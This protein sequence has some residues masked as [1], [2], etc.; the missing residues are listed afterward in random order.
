MKIKK[1]NNN[2]GGVNKIKKLKSNSSFFEASFLERPL[3]ESEDVSRFDDLVKKEAM[4][5]DTENNLFAI[6]SDNNGDPVDV[7]R[8]KK[9]KRIPLISFFKKI[10]VVTILACAIYGAYFFYFNNQNND[11]SLLFYINAPEKAVVGEL[12][13]YEIIY[14]N[15][16]DLILNNVT[17]E[18][19]LPE[20]FV[21]TESDHDLDSFKKW[22]IEKIN[23]KEKSSL[24]L[25]GYLVSA[26]D[27]ANVINARFTYTP[28]NFSSEFKKEASANTVISGL[29]FLVN[30]DYINTALVEKNNELKINFSAFQGNNL[31]DIYLEITGSD[32]FQINKKINNEINQGNDTGAGDSKVENKDIV[33]EKVGDFLWS[34]S[35]LP[36]EDG[37][38]LSVPLDFSF[39][40]K[41]NE[42]EDI[43]FKLFQKGE[44][45]KELIF[46]EKTLSFDLVNSDLNIE[47]SL[48][49]NKSDQAIDFGS[50]LN[51][52]LGYSNNGE[53]VL[54]DVALMAVIKGNFID[55]STLKDPLGGSVAGSA[56]VWTKEDLPILSE[57]APGESGEIK[58]SVNLNNFSL[59]NISTDNEIVSY[60][61][62]GLNGPLEN[63]SEDNRSNTIHSKLNS[64]LSLSEKIVYFNDDNLPVGSGPL[65]P[66]VGERTSVRVMWTIK[67]NLHD[68]ENAE[69][70]MIL[71]TGINWESDFNTN[72][73]RIFYDEDTRMVTWRLGYLPLSVYRAD[74]E[75]SI[76]L[77][78]KE[79]DRDK[80]LILSPGS[81]VKA[82]DIIT[83]SE[84][85]RKIQAKTTKLEDDEIAGLSNNGRVE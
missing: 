71:P 64:D 36:M 19:V 43:S 25:K 7:S 20:S 82:T 57:L 38:R 1:N 17:V 14:D 2:E 40:E 61:Q 84:I 46:W 83:K 6:Y 50:E 76:S 60:A 3:P 27:S 45:N 74:A 62:Y 49:N 35:N 4:L 24:K 8:V 79:S 26:L 18:L 10:F 29:G 77:T 73:G 51:Y 30:L 54:Y 48:N 85:S 59:N 22:K 81:V 5:E 70:F 47:L 23:P 80:I 66:K 39:K 12:I 58:F 56:I 68:L 21:L 55:W 52:S 31:Q 42:K 33:I 67:N 32:N 13:D 15:T 34:I 37:E 75:F 78:P 53:S 72:V 16:S 65:P 69:A 44:N 63:D 9:R 41:K 28:S 11:D